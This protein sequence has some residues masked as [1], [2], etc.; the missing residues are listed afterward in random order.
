MAKKIIP[1]KNIDINGKTIGVNTTIKLSVKTA[2]WIMGTTV[3][4][5]LSV[6]TYGYFGLKEDVKQYQTEFTTKTN[7]SI[8]N[9]EEDVTNMRLSIKGIE[10]DIKLILDRQNRDNPIKSTNIP[11]NSVMPPLIISENNSN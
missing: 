11:V 1:D 7:E 2:F 9:I 8:N 3:S 4:L 5:V 6:L 10:G